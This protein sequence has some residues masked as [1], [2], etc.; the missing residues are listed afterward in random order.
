[1]LIMHVPYRA[2]CRRL[3]TYNKA[4]A[5][6]GK[7]YSAGVLRPG[8]HKRERKMSL[9]RINQEINHSIEGMCDFYAQ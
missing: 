1:M 6:V 2:Q 4:V 9:N 3:A 5:I 7:R 8:R